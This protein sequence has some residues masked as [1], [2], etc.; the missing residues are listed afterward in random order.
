MTLEAIIVKLSV[1]FN[2]RLCCDVSLHSP[3]VLVVNLIKKSLAWSC[4]DFPDQPCVCVCVCVC[5][6][7]HLINQVGFYNF[8]A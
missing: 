2:S 3:S 5:V 6:I 7:N 8:G 1:L 4:H